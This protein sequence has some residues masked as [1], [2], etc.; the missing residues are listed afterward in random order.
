MLEELSWNLDARRKGKAA[1]ATPDLQSSQL[2]CP[3]HGS[4]G[5]NRNRLA[6]ARAVPGDRR[7][8]R[9]KGATGGPHTCSSPTPQ[10][11]EPPL[12][13]SQLTQSLTHG[14]RLRPGGAMLYA[15]RLHALMH[16]FAESEGGL[17]PLAAGRTSA[18]SGIGRRRGHGPFDGG[19][20]P[21]LVSH[22]AWATDLRPAQTGEGSG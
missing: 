2:G 15:S 16:Q 13:A 5:G 21:T 3:R 22:C 1:D 9:I 10:G 6:E 12:R 8:D 19:S 7:G 20:P 14:V 18:G 11:P 17:Q 4:L